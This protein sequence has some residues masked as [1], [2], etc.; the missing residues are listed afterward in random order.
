MEE[1]GFI[2]VGACVSNMKV[3]NTK[4]NIEQIK[5]QIENAIKNNINIIAFPE[6]SVTGYTCQDLF[7]QETLIKE[8]LKSL[9]DLKDYSKNKKIVFIVGAPIKYEG[10]LYDC[11]IVIN[12]GKI[13]GIV[14]G[15]STTN[16]ANDYLIGKTIKLFNEIIPI[17][18]DIIFQADNNEEFRFGVEVGERLWND[19]NSLNNANIVFNISASN[20]LVEKHKY[21][22]NYVQIKSL[23]NISGYVYVSAGVN[24]STTDLLYS[25]SSMIFENGKLLKENERFDFESNLIYTDIDVEKI[26]NDRI[27]NN[28]FNNSNDCRKI[29]FQ[30]NGNPNLDRKYKKTP[31]IPNEEEEKRYNEIINIQSCGLAKRLKHIGIEKCIIGLSGGLDSTLA[32]LIIIEA[33]KK[34]N[35]DNKNLIA[36]TMPGFGTTKKTYNNAI[37][38]VEKYGAT[39]KEVD[40]KQSC[41][42]HYKD[43]NHDIN[44]HDITYENA[45]AR[46]RTQILMDIAN[47]EN[48]LVV[49]TGDLSELALGWCTYNG[50]HMSMY[51]VNCNIPKTLMKHLVK[52]IADKTPEAKPVL[53]DILKTPISPELLP[54]DEKGNIKQV[55]EDSIGP[56]ILHDFYLY[57][58]LRYGANPKKIYM[59][60]K[61]TFKEDYNEEEILKWLKVFIKRFFTQQFKRNCS[62]DGIK[63][64]SIG[65]SPRGD[66]KLPSDASYEI[67][68]NDLN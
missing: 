28:L 10:K 14:P 42:I 27:K 16:F 17:G 46:E 1:Y 53:Y 8:A 3:A 12:N 58:F 65:L 54:P 44:N 52:Y 21:K 64:G 41:E 19:Q 9:Q 34:L 13:L 51:G 22:K 62:P 55:T 7:N 30:I 38:L 36:V 32:F 2:K 47:Q 4:Y 66:L 18:I 25:G 6:L 68:L 23:K 49:G 48:G 57:H 11:A 39:L 35:I 29:Y 43:I 67:W 5:I 31:F 20:E 37:E 60:A 56:Y 59:L 15:T 50:D 40:I 61:Q 45:Q 26:Q 63:V 33:Y 24:E